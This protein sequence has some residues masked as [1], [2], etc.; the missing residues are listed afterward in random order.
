MLTPLLLASLGQAEEPR[1]HAEARITIDLEAAPAV[2]LPLFGPIREAE[3]AHGWS[4]VMLYPNDGRQVAGSVFTTADDSTEVVWIMTRFDE[5][6][7]EVEYAQVRPKV[8]AGQILIRLKP[9][10]PGRTQATVTYL[11][12]ALSPEADRGVDA[13]GRH[14]PEQREHWQNAINHRLRELAGQH[15]HN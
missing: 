4:P 7:L 6:A 3:W 15:E 2:L 9:S 10:G 14:F 5:R 11:R 1:A 13:F 12:T 8:W